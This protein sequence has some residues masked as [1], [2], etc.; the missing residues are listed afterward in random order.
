MKTEVYIQ[1]RMGSTRL[2]GKILKEVDGRPLLDYLIERVNQSKECDGIV[3]LTTTEPRD[4]VIE[5][6]C[7]KR[8]VHCFR[9]SEQDVL[10]RYYKAALQRK[11]DAIVRITSDCPLI[12]PEVIDEVVG[13]FR[14][15]YP[16]IDYASNSLERT[17]PRGL[18]V[19]V[20]SFSALERAFNAANKPEER[21]HV[22][23]YIYRHPEQFV[24]K[25]LARIP[26][27]A[28]HR[29]TVDTLE[30]YD[31]IKLILE[32]LYPSNPHFRL[33]DILELLRQHP[34]WSLINAHIEQKPLA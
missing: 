16:K 14:K 12:D 4:D 7:Q 21:E 6:Y 19:E 27:L 9:G 25:N 32:N 30:D 11:P 17:Y 23:V 13:M 22:T 31:L 24:L 33:E 29:W 28:D 34:E 26:P 10:D 18:D 1:A 5:E 2:P 20:F 15:D 8:G 3:V